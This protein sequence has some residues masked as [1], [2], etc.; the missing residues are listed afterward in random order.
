MAIYKFGV[1]RNVFPE[2]LLLAVTASGS[3]GLEINV[4]CLVGGV[5][6]PPLT[7]LTYFKST[8]SIFLCGSHPPPPPLSLAAFTSF[9]RARKWRGLLEG[10]RGGGWKEERDCC[11][12]GRKKFVGGRG[13]HARAG[14]TCC[15]LPRPNNGAPEPGTKIQWISNALLIVQSPELNGGSGQSFTAGVNIAGSLVF[16]TESACVGKSPLTTG[17]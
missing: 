13:R 10:G 5:F 2:A 7:L 1:L 17:F 3:L 14:G 9:K 8:H 11:N 6:H 15:A 12:R 4:T 16:N